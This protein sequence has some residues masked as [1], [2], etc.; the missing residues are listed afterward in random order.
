MRLTLIALGTRG[1]VQPLFALGGGLR[2]AGYQVTVA[3]HEQY[4]PDVLAH[5]LEFALVSGDPTTTFARERRALT[6]GR[7]SLVTTLAGLR[8]L[9]QNYQNRAALLQQ[10][11]A[12]CLNASKDAQAIIAMMPVT[13][14]APMIA[15]RLGVP[16][17]FTAFAPLARTAEFPMLSFPTAPS[18]LP[19]YNQL[20]YEV[21]Q[22]IVVRLATP[23]L[24]TSRRSLGLPHRSGYTLREQLQSS[25]HPWLY[26]F[27]QCVVPRPSDWDTHLHVTGYWFADRTS[28][29]QPPDEVARFLAAGPPPVYVGFGSMPTDDPVSM[30]KVLLAALEQVGCRGIIATGAGGLSGASVPERIMTVA[31]LPHD[32]LLPQ[33]AAVVHH[34]GAGT[35]GAAL[36]A[37][38]PSVVIPFYSD[39][40]FWGQRVHALG[41]GPKPIP[42]RRLSRQRLAAAMN[43]ALSEPAMQQHAAALGVCIRSE[44]GIGRA[45]AVVDAAL[46]SGGKA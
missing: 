32:W 25:A 18:R 45:V 2:Q 29:W 22:R 3:T 42:A 43:Q 4:M 9:S 12:E 21:T 6:S 36:R 20:T 5:G 10:V 11:I 19:S 24:S 7:R 41:A 31:G 30:T 34:G 35:T 1:D 37:G 46:R 33:V 44:D 38:K 15:E 13:F 26:C 14:F 23:L 8:Y 40:P 17:L 39:Q 28:N 16:C 27:S